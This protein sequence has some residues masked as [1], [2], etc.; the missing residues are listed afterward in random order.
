MERAATDTYITPVLLGEAT[1]FEFISRG[2]FEPNL[3]RV[4]DLLKTRRDTMLSALGRRL[5]QARWS[6]PEGGYFIW[7]E[8]PDGV[9]AAELLERAEGVNFV[10]G[11]E[12]GGAPNTARLAYSF[13]PSE[14]IEQG[15]ER[16]AA[17]LS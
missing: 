6:H 2:N 15:V 10:P 5:P 11:T 14:E 9:T 8:L 16:L 7:L 12:F 13:V 4:N 1:V 3:V 17:A